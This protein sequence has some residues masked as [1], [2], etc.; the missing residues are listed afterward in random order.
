ML[1]SRSILVLALS[2]IMILLGINSQS[3]WLFW[4]AALLLASLVVS[5][6][7]SLSQVRNMSLVRRHKPEISEDEPLVVTLQVKND[8][9][10]SRHLLEII[11]DDPSR[12]SAGRKPRLKQPRKSL[13]DYLEEM[14]KG[15]PEQPAV[16][17]SRAAFLIPSIASA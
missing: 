4:F 3:G 5:W 9:W 7:L 12:A 14:E 16:I 17:D 8:G 2:F 6:I 13:R 1:F 10:A 15:V 11:D